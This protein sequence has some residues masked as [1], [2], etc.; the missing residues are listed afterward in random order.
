MVKIMEN[1]MNK[2]M[3]WGAHPYFWKHLHSPPDLS[4]A[5]TGKVDFNPVFL[6]KWP[7]G[8]FSRAENHPST[9]WF[10]IGQ[11]AQSFRIRNWPEKETYHSWNK[12][13]EVY[14][15]FEQNELVQGLWVLVQKYR[16]KRVKERSS[17]WW[18]V[19]Q[20][21][22]LSGGSRWWFHS[23]FIRFWIFKLKPWK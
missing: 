1:P 10:Q 6:P 2:W 18:L 8:K 13:A 12:H 4:G 3:I 22:F 5:E 23:I 7:F 21:F 16:S 14:V 20:W 15:F 17:S 9:A 11:N 19:A